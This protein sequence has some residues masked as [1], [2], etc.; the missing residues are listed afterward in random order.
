[1]LV[2]MG[3]SLQKHDTGAWVGGY[4]MAEMG[5]R[6]AKPINRKPSFFWQGVLILA[7]VL[8]LANLGA[9]AL[10]KDQRV[11]IHEAEMRAR[12]LAE[13]AAGRIWDE[14]ESVAF[15][16]IEFDRA[17]KLINPK[18]YHEVPVPRPL[19]EAELNGEQRRVWEAAQQAWG[20]ADRNENY[21]RAA[22]AYE[23]FLQSKPPGAF[24]A[25]AH[26]NRGVALERSG[27][28]AE[29]ARE[30][31]SITNDYADAFSEA[32]LPL[33][34]LAR[35][36]IQPTNEFVRYA[37]ENPCP[38]TPQIVTELSKK[39]DRSS[40]SAAILWAQ[41]E[42][43]RG[44]ASTARTVFR[45]TNATVL[46]A[47]GNAPRSIEAWADAP[48]MFWVTNYD[49]TELTNRVAHA[50]DGGA[51]AVSLPTAPLSRL[52]RK[53]PRNITDVHISGRVDSKAS[54]IE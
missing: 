45:T 51:S 4:P 11:A 43:L 2:R 17:G 50:S 27:Q 24:A 40:N 7:P 26:F 3:F 47:S 49:A 38:L 44:M 6:R 34:F 10:W 23:E 32:G 31:I 16:A 12:D 9:Y 54:A 41:Q 22:M 13:E 53:V 42:L 29:A 21:R 36:H 30:F 37:I 14:L 35:A 20:S 48:A 25:V 28:R 15:P 1:V 33:D 5:E 52:K 19:N 46:P 18:P 39:W 8:V